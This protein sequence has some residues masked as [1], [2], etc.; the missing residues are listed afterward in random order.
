MSGCVTASPLFF[1]AYLTMNAGL[2]GR[3]EEAL[4]AQPL[5]VEPGAPMGHPNDPVVLP[6]PPLEGFDAPAPAPV[7]E[8]PDQP[9]LPRAIDVVL[10]DELEDDVGELDLL[11]LPE[12][13]F[14]SLERIRVVPT[15]NP[16]LL[17]GVVPLEVQATVDAHL[18]AAKDCG[19]L[20][21]PPYSLPV[22]DELVDV[23]EPPYSICK[24]E[25]GQPWREEVKRVSDQHPFASHLPL[26]VNYRQYPVCKCWSN[27][28]RL[29]RLPKYFQLPTLVEAYLRV[30]KAHLVFSKSSAVS[31]LF[32]AS[33]G[34][35]ADL[36]VA[37]VCPVG[38]LPYNGRM[39]GDHCMRVDC[40]THSCTPVYGLVSYPVETD[41][42]SAPSFA[43]VGASGKS[44]EPKCD[45]CVNNFCQDLWHRFLGTS[46]LEAK[47]RCSGL[48]DRF[49]SFRSEAK[50]YRRRLER[51]NTVY[52]RMKRVRHN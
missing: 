27:F 47:Y 49:H 1:V 4:G 19:K 9:G 26:G 51:L 23:W 43:L 16:F 14:S 42:D 11:P 10:D 31:S 41:N 17:P 21:L 52:E 40:T 39:V 7:E 3:L 5:F 50:H 22:T 6:V 32:S 29:V 35:L 2:L 24:G 34:A 30:I 28:D 48:P 18:E 20:F 45:S 44:W 36:V 38:W 25:C 15:L 8:D 33:S 37:Y 13:G 46:P 12:G